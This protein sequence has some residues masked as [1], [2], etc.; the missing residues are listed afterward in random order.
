M[1]RY[2]MSSLN[3]PDHNMDPPDAED[4]EPPERFYDEATQ[5]LRE[6]LWADDVGFD[7]LTA[8]EMADML[9]SHAVTIDQSWEEINERACKLAHEAVEDDACADF[10]RKRDRQK[11]EDCGEVDIGD[12]RY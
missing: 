10:D 7:V 3:I 6:R 5:E 12:S 8:Q 1:P 11:D 2:T 4:R 9:T